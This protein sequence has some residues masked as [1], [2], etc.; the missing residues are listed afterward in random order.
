MRFFGVV[1]RQE[2]WLG[3]L[4]HLL[5]FPLG[6]FYFVFLVTGLSLGVG[7]VVVWVG[8]P[9]LLVVAGAW[10]LFG[11]FER[12]QAQYLLGAAVP[13]APREWEKVEG[14]WGKLKAHF[15]S[16]ATWK[17][18][19]YLLAKLVFGTVSFTL[20]VVAASMVGWFLAMPVFTAFDVPIVNDTWVPPLWFSIISVPL[21]ILVFFVS[22]HL[23]NAWSWACARWAEVMFRGPELGTAPVAAADPA[24]APRQAAA[25]AAPPR[26]PVAPPPPAAPAPPQTPVPPQ[27]SA[28]P[29]ETSV[30]AAASATSMPP[31][32]PAAPSPAAPTPAA[33]APVRP[34]S[35][36]ETTS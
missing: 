2:T 34:P 4:F 33:P 14:V 35:D 11:A 10:W 18:L 7:L 20:L 12:L 15:G 29:S 27:T 31:S 1:A 23:L 24:T 5:A 30:P 36:D 26:A 17:D 32:S 8:I 6:L 9:I 22:L 28:A 3:M 21:G 25:I 16:A 19:V 13:P